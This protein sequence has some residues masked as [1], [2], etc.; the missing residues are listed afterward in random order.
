[1]T[2]SNKK[3]HVKGRL[4]FGSSNMPIIAKNQTPDV[5]ATSETDR[6]GDI[7]DLDFPNLDALGLDFNLSKLLVDFDLGGEGLDFS[8]QQATSYTPDSSTG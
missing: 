2:R 7:L 5:T 6:E 4:D 3:D 8:S 1:M